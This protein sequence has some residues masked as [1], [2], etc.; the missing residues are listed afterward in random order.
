MQVEE[1]LIHLS[2]N[3][4]RQD[5]NR[6]QR[7]CLLSQKYVTKGGSGAAQASECDVTLMLQV[8]RKLCSFARRALAWAFTSRCSRVAA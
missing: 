2:L 1:L 3:S 6:V 7:Q 5:L 8:N 4:I